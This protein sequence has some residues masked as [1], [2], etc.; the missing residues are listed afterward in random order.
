MVYYHQ[1]IQ[2]LKVGVASVAAATNN[3]A[4]PSE[5]QEVQRWNCL[6]WLDVHN[7]LRKNCIDFKQRAPHKPTS[8]IVCKE[9]SR[10]FTDPQHEMPDSEPNTTQRGGQVKK[11][12]RY[13]GLIKYH[14]IFFRKSKT[15][16]QQPLED[17]T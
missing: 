15:N 16:L 2:E 7:K 4:F 8:L 14:L 6:R 3:S 11:D 1:S 10:T 12:H 9:N 5:N 13:T 17:H